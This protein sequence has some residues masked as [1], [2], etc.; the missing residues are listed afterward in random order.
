[1]GSAG[2]GTFQI[3]PMGAIGSLMGEDIGREGRKAEHDRVAHIAAAC[4]RPITY[5]LV[6]YPSDPDDWRM[7]LAETQRRHETGLQIHPQVASR[8]GGMLEMLDGHHRFRFRPS[9]IEIRDL[10]VAQRAAA[11]R[12][13][14]RRA[15]ILAEGDV[16]EGH[17]TSTM[18]AIV[19]AMIRSR[20]GAFYPVRTPI[21]FEPEPH[22]TVGAIAAAAGVDAQEWAY[23]YLTTGDGGNV[24]ADLNTNYPQ[25]HLDAMFEMLGHP[26]VLSGLGD[27]GAHLSLICDASM[28]TSQLMFWGRDR[29][30]GRRL[31]VEA[32]VANLSRKNAQA[33][34][35]GDR[36]VLQQGRRADINVIDF[37]NLSLGLPRI[38]R[39]LPNGA[40]RVL[41]ESSGYLATIVNGV[42]TRRNDADTGERPGRLFRSR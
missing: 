28:P 3:I 39:D 12:E 4:G 2:R 30:R 5:S 33:Y 15:A 32:I 21:N 17:V 34:G 11:M 37:E 31:A 16:T 1:M 10:P 25:G 26:L 6:Q 13:P 29:T 24:L 23:D 22:H 18:D 41:Q 7:M 19:L 38:A 9:Y 20:A 42:A 8:P 40:P 27:G 36:G 35:M 14:A